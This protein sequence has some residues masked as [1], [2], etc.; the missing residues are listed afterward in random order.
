MTSAPQSTNLPKGW[1]RTTLGNVVSP[2]R[3]RFNPGQNEERRFVGLEHIESNSG[4]I[5][6]H[7]QSSSLRSTKT[8][9]HAGDI[10]YGRLRPYLNKVCV[11][12]FD[13]I[14]STD[15]LVFPRNENVDSR[16]L[17]NL[18][19]TAKFVR[20]ATQNMKG[21]QHPRVRFE[22]ISQYPIQFPPLKEQHRIV[23]K[24]DELITRL[25]VG[26]RELRVAKSTLAR[27]K[28]AVLKS[29]F[30]GKLTKEWRAGKGAHGETA[31]EFL[32]RI[33][34]GLSH[35][36][37]GSLGVYDLPN[38]WMWTPA[39][40]LVSDIRYGSSKKCTEKREGTPVLRIPNIL[41]GKLDL[42]NLKYAKFDERELV[43]LSMQDGD[44]LVCRTNGSLD[45]VGRTAVFESAPQAFAFAS[46]L[47]RMRLFECDILPRYLNFL[48]YSG[49]ARKHIESRARTTA[50]QFNIN[51]RTLESLPIPLAPLQEQQKIVGT[52][53]SILTL[54]REVEHSIDDNITKTSSLRASVL[55]TAFQG[56]LVEQNP[57]DEPAS[58]AMERLIASKKT[59]EME[60][61]ANEQ[62]RLV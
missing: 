50:G 53:E 61:H 16:Y 22:E 40:L 8:V 31:D 28:L 20:F 2:S 43:N 35:S 29:A 59:T 54:T 3:M 12:D 4:L 5:L 36:A 6:A 17:A 10:L 37:L 38:G 51:I 7:G 32:R 26:I 42:T 48:F 52:L 41:L 33:R 21:V 46:Y 60:R 27:Y 58:F 47:I 62:T 57:S 39:S 13:G 23:S 14:C 45:L 11:P 49:S 25:N 34:P 15:I 56:K 55:N 9:F 30:E 18:L 19:L 44:L 24:I 1:I